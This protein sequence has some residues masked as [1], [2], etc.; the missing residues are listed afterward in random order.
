MDDFKL[1]AAVEVALT[2]EGH[3][4]GVKADNGDV[5]LTINK[6][7]L[8]LNRLEEELKSIAGWYPRG[9][10]RPDK[11]RSGISSSRYLPQMQFRTADQNTPGG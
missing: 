6:H 9:K 3:H 10:N 8:L 11:S 5:T 7:V 4:V 2:N 1:A